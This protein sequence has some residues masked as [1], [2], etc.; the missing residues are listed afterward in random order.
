MS[1]AHLCISACS[2]MTAL[3]D[4]SRQTKWRHHMSHEIC[5]SR[6]CLETG[7]AR[8]RSRMVIMNL[9]S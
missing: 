7:Q 8:I 3:G 5:C 2:R 9:V 1:A 4:D 6:A